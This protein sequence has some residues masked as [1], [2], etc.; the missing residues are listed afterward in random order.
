[1]NA[2]QR[3]MAETKTKLQQYNAKRREEQLFKDL[4]RRNHLGKL[5]EETFLALNGV[6]I[7]VT[8][9]NGFFHYNGMNL[10]E[11][12]LQSYLQMMQAKVHEQELQ[13]MDNET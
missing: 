11:H 3:R 12:E 13:G 8:Y 5:F 2:F 6:A 9:K 1:M 4:T 10:R 7:K